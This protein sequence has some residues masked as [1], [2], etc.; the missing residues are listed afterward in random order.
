MVRLVAGGNLSND[1]FKF[2][3]NRPIGCRDMDVGFGGERFSPRCDS[4]S[5]AMRDDH[6]GVE[7]GAPMVRLVAG[8]DLSNDGFKFRSNRPIGCRDMV[9]GVGGERFAPR[10][11]SF[12][13][14]MRD[15]HGGVEGAA[16]MVRLVAGGNLSNDGFK[17]RSNRPIGCRDMVIGVGGERFSPAA[18]RFRWRR[19]TTVTMKRERHR[20]CD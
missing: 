19:E 20:W 9:I 10:C 7:G 4:F 14:A 12:S 3:F 6:G 1:G 18:I 13:L 8:G 16:P 17:F 2:R 11:D 15:D 5:L